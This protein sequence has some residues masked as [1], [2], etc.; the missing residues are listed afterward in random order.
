MAEGYSSKNIDHLGLISG[1]C[2]E[3]DI[4]AQID[5]L[6]G[7][8]S[9]HQHV[10]T[11]QAV[12]AML[13][14]GLGFVN[15]RLYLVS[16]FFEDKAVE[17][18][19]G[20]GIEASH[21]NDDRLG[22]ALDALHE[23]GLTALFASLASNAMEQLGHQPKWV[24]LD[25]STFH[26][27]GS[28]NSDKESDA[29]LHITYGHSKDHRPD[30]PQ[31]A[32]QL[33]CDH[34]SG[35]PL[36]MESLHGNN[37][38]SV[39]FRNTIEQFSSQLKLTGVERII[40]DSK[41]YSEQTLLVLHKAGM[42]WLTRVPSTL[43]QV[44]KLCAETV[45]EQMSWID[46]AYAVQ[47]HQVVYAGIA[48][49]WLVVHSKAAGKREEKT[50]KRKW[51]K[52]SQK[53]A[54]EWKKLQRQA[55]HCR[56]DA[57]DA[58]DKWLK[59]QPYMQLQDVEVQAV[60]RYAQKGQPA[61]DALPK[62]VEYYL[63]GSLSTDLQAYQKQIFEQSLFVL[64]SDESI[65]AQ[66]Q[67]KEMLTAYKAQHGVERGFRFLKDPQVVASSFFVKNPQRVQA[68]LFI[69]T[70]CLFVYSLLEYKIRKTLQDQQKTVPDQKGKPTVTPTARW[71]FHCFLGIHLLKLPDEKEIVL[72][73]KE[74][75][76][77]ILSLLPDH[78]LDT[79]S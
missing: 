34:L 12:V 28:Y 38:D 65:D 18:L 59:K 66:E 40:A 54:E 31:A 46:E 60:K 70:L 41:L 13:L 29:Q 75:H 4:A 35:I 57:L 67:Q 48:Q 69:M 49:H 68:L 64:A 19:I 45:L 62:E 15:Q 63:L 27:H 79:Y 44:K 77:T 10:S 55:F 61:K 2:K 43:L 47:P 23:H 52:Q 20:A 26:V 71:I 7:P 8:T 25:S 3:F 5:R 73:L 36:H 17:R 24:H 51:G 72:N 39:S 16:R 14:N 78:Y 33:I 58:A 1:I 50:L 42:H 76:K 56:E 21:L 22:R 6:L 53:A 37:S 32:L 74:V 11:G 9:A 30:L